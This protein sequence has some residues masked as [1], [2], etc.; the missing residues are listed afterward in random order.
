MSNDPPA[1]TRSRRIAIHP[2]K[3]PFVV[4]A[5][6]G[7]TLGDGYVVVASG[8]RTITRVP[9]GSD[10]T[11]AMKVPLAAIEIPPGRVDAF[12]KAGSTDA[13]SMDHTGS[14][15]VPSKSRTPAP[16]GLIPLE[17]TAVLPSPAP[18]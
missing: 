2:L 1:T 9:L 15:P 11:T 5:V 12:W 6:V 10:V 16:S 18:E 14:T 13:R 4:Q 3:E 8:R 7:N 17:A